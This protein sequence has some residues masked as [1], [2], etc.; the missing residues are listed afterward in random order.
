MS[1]LDATTLRIVRKGVTVTKDGQ[2]GEVVKT[3]RGACLV[4][5]GSNRYPNTEYCRELRVVESPSKGANRV[6]MTPTQRAE[7]Q[8][9]RARIKT[10]ETAKM[11]A[12]AEALRQRLRAL[13]RGEDL[14]E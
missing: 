8:S 13:I 6:A 2:R 5:W 3:S 11:Y 1:N 12:S 7:A 4:R 14:S 10:L 9:L